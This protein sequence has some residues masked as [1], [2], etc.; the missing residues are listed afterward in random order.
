MES[1]F[2][3]LKKASE[4]VVAASKVIELHLLGATRA[5]ESGYPH[6]AM[7]AL[8]QC[9]ASVLAEGEVN[10]I[11][12]DIYWKSAESRSVLDHGAFPVAGLLGDACAVVLGLV[13]RSDYDPEVGLA[14]LDATRSVERLCVYLDQTNSGAMNADEKEVSKAVLA[15]IES[16]IGRQEFPEEEK[17]FR[18]EDSKGIYQF[19][20]ETK[21]YS[22]IHDFGVHIWSHALKIAREGRPARAILTITKANLDEAFNQIQKEKENKQ[23][24]PLSRLLR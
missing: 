17:V 18:Y 20:E 13:D 15:G 12:D 14:A 10:G 21:M 4:G 11:P 22:E 23:G 19:T 16:A 1:T 5:G 2:E 8:Y 7:D 6:D 24:K 3:R 9:F